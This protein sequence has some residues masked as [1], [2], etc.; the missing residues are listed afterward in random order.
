MEVALRAEM[1]IQG[2]LRSFLSRGLDILTCLLQMVL[3]SLPLHCQT[4]IPLPL[5]EFCSSGISAWFSSLSIDAERKA[6][7]AS[8]LGYRLKLSSFGGS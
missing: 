8:Q 5:G 4:H 3:E 6:E 2:L 1:S 7:Q